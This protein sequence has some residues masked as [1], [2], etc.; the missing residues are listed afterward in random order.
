MGGGRGRACRPHHLRPLHDGQVQA[1]HVHQEEE[2]DIEGKE[3]KCDCE[4][5]EG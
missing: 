5:E 2:E 4:R 1:V 3:E